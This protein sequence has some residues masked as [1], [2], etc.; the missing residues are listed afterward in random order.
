MA[1][2]G[3]WRLP[4]LFGLTF[5][6]SLR[7]VLAHRVNL[8]FDVALAV[9]TLAGALAAV[10]LVYTQTSSLAGWSKPA[11][12]VLVGTFQL[13][14]GVRSAF[15]DPNLGWFAERIRDGRMDLFLLQ[16][17]PSL[18][19][20]SLGS[21]AP[22]ALTQVALGAG[23]VGLGLVELGTLPSA[24]SFAAWLVLLAVGVGVTWAL[25][26]LLACL[27]FWAP[28]LQLDVMYGAA[29]E[30][31]RYPVDIYRRP[32]RFVL[33]YLF[34]M[35]VITTLPTSALIEGPSL[36][37]VLVTAAAGLGVVLLAGRVWTLGLRRYTG[38]TS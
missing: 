38:A 21:H 6:M 24:V 15:V 22:L 35:A 18:F 2:R 25:G 7:R 16:P 14:G 17:A 4:M 32:M 5:S 20:A 1:T 8:A 13:M 11:M 30:L 28:R 34:P 36:V 37:S 19:L 9:F 29:W 23:V 33:T 10:Q 3:R 31:A 27:A 26:V 12:F